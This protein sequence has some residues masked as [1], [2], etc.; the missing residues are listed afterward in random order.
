[1]SQIKQK[2]YNNTLNIRRKKNKNTNTGPR[3]MYTGRQINPQQYM[4]KEFKGLR[5]MLITN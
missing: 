2:N 1:M 4:K 3:I 5:E